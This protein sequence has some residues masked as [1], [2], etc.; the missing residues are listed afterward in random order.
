MGRIKT[1]FVKNVAKELMEK[2]PNSFSKSFEDNKKAMI[3]F[4][5]FT[6]R[7]MRNLVAGYISSMKNAKPIIHRVRIEDKKKD[8]RFGRRGRRA[9]SRRR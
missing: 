5:S 4:V 2:H 6:S 3:P 8:D 7:K 9:I 1:T